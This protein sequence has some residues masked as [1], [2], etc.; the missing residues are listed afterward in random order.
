MD[1]TKI[2]SLLE[3]LDDNIDDLQEALAPVLGTNLTDIASKLPLI[4]KAQLHVLWA[5]TIESVLFCK[6]EKVL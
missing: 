6:S 3:S 1:T 4:D 5:Y 2:E